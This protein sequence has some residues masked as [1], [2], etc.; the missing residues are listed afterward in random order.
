M[1]VGLQRVHSVSVDHVGAFGIVEVPPSGGSPE[2]ISLSLDAGQVA[3]LSGLPGS[4]LTTTGLTLL[5]PHATKGPIAYVDVR[6]WANPAVAWEIGIA[7]ERLVVV[8]NRD[9][10][11]W[12]RVVAAL[13]SG[14]R[15]VYAEVPRGVRDQVLRKLAAKARTQRTPIVLRP[16]DG[17]IPS[18]IATLRL[19]ARAVEWEGTDAG[20]GRLTA[21]RMVLEVSGKSVQGM[22]YTIEMEDHG[23]DDLCV[24]SRVG[25]APSRRLA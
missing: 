7:P 18:G 10:V 8:R 5:A 17:T 3:G 9:V 1:V 23:A 15:G 6:G 24:V 25:V 4:G 16:V 11:T 2:P 13:L 21:R 22:R 12:G 14:T 19:E 20:H